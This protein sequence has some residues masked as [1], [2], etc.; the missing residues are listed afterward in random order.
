[1]TFSKILED[2]EHYYSEKIEMHGPTPRGVD[3]SSHESQ[4]L[5][6]EQLLKIC[7]KDIEFSINDFGCGYG[8]LLEY[9]KDENY[10]CRYYGFDVSDRMIKVA[11]QLHSDHEQC[12][13]T[14]VESEM[15]EADYTVASGIFNVK[16]QTGEAEWFH[17]ILATLNKL[18]KLSTRGFAFNVLTSYSDSDRMRPDL[19]YA[20]PSVLFDYCKRSFSRFVALLHDYPLYEFTILVRLR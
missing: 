7:D 9:L 16:L 4:K 15:T 13:F 10:R 5:R 3:W 20:D 2:V 1:M 17:Y 12:K 11:R 14:S 18:S 8:G 19:Y 6:F